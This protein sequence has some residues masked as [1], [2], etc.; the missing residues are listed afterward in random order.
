[1]NKIIYFVLLILLINIPN[2]F[3][4][5]EE[6]F[7]EESASDSIEVYLIDNYVNETGNTKILILSWMTN[8]PCKSKVHLNGF[9]EFIV[10]DSLS[11]FHQ[12]KIDLSNYQFLSNEQ[13]FTIL[14][15]LEDGKTFTSEKYSFT[16]QF[17]ENTQS[18]ELQTSSIYYLYNFIYGITLWLIPAPT[19]AFEKQT[20][21]FALIKELP[22]VSVGSSSA[23][24]NFPYF[25]VYA[26]YSHVFNGN[27]KNTFR[28]GIKLLYELSELKHFIS[29]GTGVVTNFKGV[30]GISTEAGFSF[31][32]ILNTFELYTSYSH[33]FM[34]DSNKNFGVL[35]FGLFTSSFSINLNY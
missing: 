25:Y 24:K 6:T 33:N 32:K 29:I 19:L 27:V 5:E 11:D 4:Q 35:S 34:N 8:V 26:G 18:T 17:D 20:T 21:K 16:I 23:Y 1:M 2:L 15:E 3:A 22:I 30:K 12:T 28:S 7:I 14:S 31:L 9:G 13:S 10:S